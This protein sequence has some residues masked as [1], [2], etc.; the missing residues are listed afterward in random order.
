MIVFSVKM[1]KAIS[2]VS[3]WEMIPGDMDA[4]NRTGAAIAAAIENDKDQKESK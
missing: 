3:N 1:L 2:R 4:I